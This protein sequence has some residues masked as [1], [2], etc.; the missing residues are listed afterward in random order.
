MPSP[1]PP[2][3]RLDPARRRAQIIDAAETVF[4]GRDPAEVTFEEIAE[5]AGVSRALVYNYFGD[6]GGLLAAVYLRTFERLDEELHEALHRPLPP[7]DRLR[8][9]VRSYLHFATTDAAA[10]KLI[11]TAE[12]IDHPLLQSARRARYERLAGAWGGSPT[13]RVLARGVVGMLEAATIDWLEHRDCDLDEVTEL[14]VALLWNGIAPFD[15]A[16]RAGLD[17]PSP[18]P[19][20]SGPT[21]PA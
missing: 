15:V 4:E 14:L 1:R 2:R 21:V 8:A 12:A 13:A 18:S 10:W 19:S 3:R 20:R 5:A 9:V 11:G 17:P 6:R 16:F 7:E